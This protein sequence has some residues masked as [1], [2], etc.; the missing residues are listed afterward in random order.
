MRKQYIDQR[1]KIMNEWFERGESAQEHQ[2]KF[3]AFIYLWISL[4]VG[5]KIE[6]GN[7]IP[8]TKYMQKDIGDLECIKYWFKSHS[9][10]VNDQIKRNWQTLSA[11]GKRTGSHF[12]DPIIDTKSSNL[13][14]RFARLKKYF[15]GTYAYDKDKQPAEDFAELLNKIRNNLFH[16]DKSY[17]N[18]S[19][20]ELLGAIL[21]VLKNITEEVVESNQ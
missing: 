19:D 13:K 14:V 17:D 2:N 6:M 20:R 12:G 5:C 15:N 21:P 18:R 9:A 16:G 8:A 11:L 3:E 4:I 10:F 7:N 1:Q